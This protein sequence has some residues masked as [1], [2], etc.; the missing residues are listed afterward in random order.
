MPRSPSLLVALTLGGLYAPV[1]AAQTTVDFTV[2]P[3]LAASLGVTP[4]DVTSQLEA[5]AVDQLSLLDPSGFMTSMAEAAAIAGKGIGVD[6][7]SN[8]QQFAFGLSLGTGVNGDALAL[9]RPPTGLPSAGFAFQASAMASINLGLLAGTASDENFDLADRFVI[10]LHGMSFTSPVGGQAFQGT[11]TNYGA[12]VTVKLIG[13]GNHKIFEYGGLDLT[14]GFEHAAYRLA[15]TGDLPIG[16]ASGASQFGWQPTGS[17][18][19]GVATNS[20]PLEV[21][22]NLRVSVL[23]VFLGVGADANFGTSDA[24]GSLTGPITGDLGSG[25]TEI[26]TGTVTN[27][28]SGTT[29]P[30]ALRGFGGLQVNILPVKVYVMLQGSSAMSASLQAGVRVAM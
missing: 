14:T 30:Y 1:A 20:I 27:T 17:Y 2:V 5:A 25:P 8:P 22:S 12:H 9:T 24:V 28:S 3:A 19:L 6:Y 4:A 26:G 23:T 15:L 11:M 29:A 7:A 10:S 13:R 21:S 18:T 16:G